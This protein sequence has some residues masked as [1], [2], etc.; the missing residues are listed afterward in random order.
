MSCSS[1][2]DADETMKGLTMSNTM[3]RALVDLRHEV[4][5]F[6]RR[7]EADRSTFGDTTRHR[8]LEARLDDVDRRLSNVELAFK[9]LAGKIA[10]VL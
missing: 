9:D 3:P 10:A 6:K 4:E 5:L 7:L 8:T 1:I 2:S